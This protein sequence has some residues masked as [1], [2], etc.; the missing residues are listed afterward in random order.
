[1][2]YYNVKLQYHR[3]GSFSPGR[4]VMADTPSSAAEERVREILRQ[5][6]IEKLPIRAFVENPYNSGVLMD[7]SIVQDPVITVE[8]L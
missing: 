1:M 8:V 5:R 7:L 4:K 3:G 6:V 2:K